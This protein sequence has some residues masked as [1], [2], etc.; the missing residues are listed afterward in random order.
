MI[1]W[2]AQARVRPASHTNIRRHR[3]EFQIVS[4]FSASLTSVNRVFN[5]NAGPSALPLSV[6]ERIREELLDWRGSGMSV[7]EMS[8]RS[9]EFESINA[10]AEQKL[11][12]LLGISDD[13]AVIFMQG[14][15]SMQRSEEHTSELQSP[16]Y[17]V[18]RL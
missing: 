15:G 3:E 16:M 4:S 5:F 6:L 9:P 8:H 12:N 11:R 1:F 10:S 14:G 7:M 2:C 17:L 13:Y 18:C